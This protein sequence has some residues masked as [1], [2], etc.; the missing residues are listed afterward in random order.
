MVVDGVVVLEDFLIVPRGAQVK[1]VAL[2]FV[3]SGDVFKLRNV[4]QVRSDFLG[5]E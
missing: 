4:G 2:D 1:F 5:R 3:E